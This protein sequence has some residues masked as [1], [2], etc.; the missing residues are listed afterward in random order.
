M[1][2]D[3]PNAPERHPLFDEMLEWSYDEHGGRGALS[4]LME[5]LSI[6][7]EG[8]FSGIEDSREAFSIAFWT[9]SANVLGDT[10]QWPNGENIYSGDPG[11]RALLVCSSGKPQPPKA[12]S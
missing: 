2:T 11:F 10:S 6:R 12:P 3:Q 9:A 8:H 1:N 7:L 4:L 5:K